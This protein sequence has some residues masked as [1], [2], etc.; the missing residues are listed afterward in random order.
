MGQSAEA[1]ACRYLKAQGLTLITTNY[2]CK[3]GEID[4]IMQD[5]DE[6]VFVEVKY[7]T[8][9][10]FGHPAEYFDTHKRRKFESALFHFMQ[11][12]GL[13]PAHIPHRIDLVAITGSQIQWIKRL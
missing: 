7:R 1:R 9:T 3:S 13:N 2:H 12:K 6:L 8:R 11:Y 4:L 5:D 10:H